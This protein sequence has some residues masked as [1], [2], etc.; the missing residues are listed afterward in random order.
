MSAENTRNLSSYYVGNERITNRN[1]EDGIDVSS[2]QFV[3]LSLTG[4]LDRDWWSLH[5]KSYNIIIT[6]HEQDEN[7]QPVNY[8]HQEEVLGEYKIRSA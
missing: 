7:R 4:T 6:V 8:Y 3:S 1:V 2:R 5:F